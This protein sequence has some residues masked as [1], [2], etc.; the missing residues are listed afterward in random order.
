MSPEYLALAAERR[1]TQ[2]APHLQPE[3]F[4]YDFSSWV[5]PYTK[6][7]CAGG[8]VAVVLQDWASADG[9]SGPPKAEIQL[10]G[11][12]PALL[13][14]RRLET[15]L[16]KV[17]G[18]GLSDVYATNVFPFV[19]RGGMSAPIRSP[20]VLRYARQFAVRELQLAEPVVVLALG[21][22]AHAT[23]NACGVK[24]VALPHPAA[25]IGSVAAHDSAWR[26][27]LSTSGYA[28]LVKGSRVA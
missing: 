26:S 5:S 19:K 21:A 8:G 9:L 13:T 4:G 12:M 27:A 2:P 23:L 3:D 15:L 11:R 20:E 18:L 14:N 24:N 6:G 22:V 17:L 1:A 16:E 28:A 10:H 7:A 25:R